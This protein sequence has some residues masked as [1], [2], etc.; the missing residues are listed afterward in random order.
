MDGSDCVTKLQ[1][2]K[3]LKGYILCY[4]YSATVS[5]KKNLYKQNKTFHFIP[6]LLVE[7]EAG[8]YLWDCSVAQIVSRANVQRL[9]AGQES[10]GTAEP[11]A[12][13]EF[14]QELFSSSGICLYTEKPGAQPPHT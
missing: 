10:G 13:S 14:K 2:S 6:G 7:T 9:G 11:W 4:V 12:F 1:A 8:Q 3:W 5:K